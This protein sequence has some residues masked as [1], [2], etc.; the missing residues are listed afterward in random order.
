MWNLPP[1]LWMAL[2]STS[3]LSRLTLDRP[4][5]GGGRDELTQSDVHPFP[6]LPQ[7]RDESRS[8]CIQPKYNTNQKCH[9]RR[10]SIP[11]FRFPAPLE[12]G[13]STYLSRHVTA[14]LAPS[15]SR[16]RLNIQHH[17]AGKLARSASSAVREGSAR[18]GLPVQHVCVVSVK[19]YVD[20]TE[21]QREPP[22]FEGSCAMLRRRDAAVAVDRVEAPN[23]LNSSNLWQTTPACMSQG[24]GRWRWT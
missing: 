6:Q 13:C 4:W 2:A 5:R 23:V 21:G 16:Q 15:P 10:N 8:A 17:C 14:P 12:S 1:P 22:L 20:E 3:G 19:S 24:V 7:S 11:R 18:E 9:R